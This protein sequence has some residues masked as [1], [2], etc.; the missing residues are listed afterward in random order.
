MKTVFW[1]PN[2]TTFVTQLSMP[3]VTFAENSLSLHFPFSLSLSIS[4]SLF[5]LS[6]LPAR[7][8]ARSLFR[9][10]PP[11]RQHRR[12]RSQWLMKT[13]L[14]PSIDPDLPVQ[15]PTPVLSDSIPAGW[16]PV[17][18]NRFLFSFPG[19][20]RPADARSGTGTARA[21]RRRDFL[22]KTPTATAAAHLG[23]R[24]RGD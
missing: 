17:R 24:I 5:S 16:F 8:L 10:E 20:P 18:K 22:P 4:L 11:P 7:K 2:L 1:C 15:N 3:R 13:K 21:P 12:R 19:D 23:L 9:R 6:T 14:S